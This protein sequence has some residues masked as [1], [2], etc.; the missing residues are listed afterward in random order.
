MS[1]EIYCFISMI[2]ASDERKSK[3]GIASSIEIRSN[4]AVLTSA[5]VKLPVLEKFTIVKG[6]VQIRVI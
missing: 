3:I 1:D 6:H 4:F 2:L 5:Y